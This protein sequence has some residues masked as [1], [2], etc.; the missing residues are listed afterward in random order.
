MHEMKIRYS[1]FFTVQTQ[2]CAA[3]VQFEVRTVLD[4]PTAGDVAADLYDLVDHHNLTQLVLDLAG[5]RF[6]SSQALGTLV[7]LQRKVNAAGGRLILAGVSQNIARMFQITR[8]DSLFTF[9]P[10]VDQAV[11]VLRA[12]A[13]AHAP[14]IARPAAALWN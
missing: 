7:H 11:H 14:A 12:I 1:D 13:Q 9:C 4:T 6:L 5:M 2:P 8:L 10:D 3:I